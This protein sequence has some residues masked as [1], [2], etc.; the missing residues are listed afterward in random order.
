MNYG[1]KEMMLMMLMAFHRTLEAFA[2]AAKASSQNGQRWQDFVRAGGVMPLRALET[3]VDREM[4]G[5][6]FLAGMEADGSGI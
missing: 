6:G 3:L 4:K 5:W 1:D 2:F